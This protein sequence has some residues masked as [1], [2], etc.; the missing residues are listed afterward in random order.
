MSRTERRFL[1][2]PSDVPIRYS[3]RE[4]VTDERDY[5]RNIGEGGL[6]FNARLAIQPGTRIHI[7]IPIADPV[8]EADGIVAWCDRHGAIFE[9]GVRFEGV[10]DRY[11]VRMVEQVCH[12]EHYRHEIQEREGRSLS[13]EEAALEWIQK[14]AD[15][16]PGSG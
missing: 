14:Y 15:R 13:S 7:Q 1:R 6:C 4:V 2:H 16:F 5:L 11:G 8:F 10:E 9:V 3:L 12:I